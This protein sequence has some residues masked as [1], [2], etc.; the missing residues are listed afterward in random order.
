MATVRTL[1]A[2]LLGVGLAALAP[3]MAAGLI[4][5]DGD[6][7]ISRVE[8]RTAVAD[9]AQAADADKDGLITSA[10]FPFTSADLALFDNNGDG[11]VTSVGVQEFIDG[12]DVAFDAMDADMDNYL[13]IAELHD[14]NG[15]YGIAAPVSM[16]LGDQ[17]ASAKPRPLSRG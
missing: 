6:D 1:T 5:H 11:A 4:D 10:E 8:Y 12:M 2:L 17:A 3:V 14:A 15:R 13:S 9:I 16:R 7:R